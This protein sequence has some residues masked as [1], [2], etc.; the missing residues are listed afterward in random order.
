[1]QNQWKIQK[2][3]CIA[4]AR[5]FIKLSHSL[6]DMVVAVIKAWVGDL[7]FQFQDLGA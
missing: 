1:M 2:L 7:H 3:S 6:S 4:S 5:T